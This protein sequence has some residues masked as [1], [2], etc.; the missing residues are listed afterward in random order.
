MLRKFT[1]S[2]LLILWN[3]LLFAQIPPHYYD[4]AV[5]DTGVVMKMALHNIIKGH[6]VR[7]YSQLWTDFK[8]T[9]KK[10]NGKVW[11]IYSDIPGGTPPYEFTFVTDQ[12]GSYQNEG[13]C[14][15]REHSFPKSWFG[16]ASP[17]VSDLFHI[18]PT[19]GKVNGW[20]SNYPYGEVSNP[21][22][23]TQ[24]GSKLGPCTVA[25]YS[26]TAFEPIDEYKGDLA[27]TYFYMAV[28]YYTEDGNWPGSAMV[29][30]A[31]PKAWALAMLYQ[32]HLQDTVSQKEIDRNNAIYALQHNRNPFIDHPEWVDTIWFYKPPT[33]DA[34]GNQVKKLDAV[35]MPNPVENTAYILLL[36]HQNKQWIIQVYDF[37]G[38][39]LSEKES[40]GNRIKIE[41]QNLQPGAYLLIIR[42][43]D[44]EYS[45]NLKFI[46]Q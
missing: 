31:E 15:N 14:Y 37:A 43:S 21:T 44:N 1:L 22:V 4:S 39:K 12:C 18:Y 11:D 32:W 38:R 46:K 3:L 36:N 5:G 45:S 19:D 30:G 23:T 27:R 24:N 33:P 34:I 29:N 6:T 8:S 20:R 2:T 42:S 10:A 25:G 41:T 9:D 40:R 7:S 17:M 13:D 16:N 26:G 35:L 28:R